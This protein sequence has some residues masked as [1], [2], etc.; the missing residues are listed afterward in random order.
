MNI[1][2]AEKLANKLKSISGNPNISF[3]VVQANEREYRVIQ[4]YKGEPVGIV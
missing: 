1:G 3:E 2:A 4:L